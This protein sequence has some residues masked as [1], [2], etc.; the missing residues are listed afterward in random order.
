MERILLISAAIKA[1]IVILAMAGRHHDWAV[2]AMLA[3]ASLVVIFDIAM[4][5]A[6]RS[7]NKDIEKEL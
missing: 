7:A 3:L 6:I 5:V 4:A 2:V 1:V